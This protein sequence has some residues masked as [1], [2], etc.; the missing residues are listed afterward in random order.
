MVHVSGIGIVVVVVIIVAA[1]N[2]VASPSAPSPLFRRLTDVS[3]WGTPGT[4]AAKACF[5]DD[6]TLLL[7][8]SNSACAVFI[9]YSHVACLSQAL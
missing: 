9:V 5:A 8:I 7:D 4:V 1:C 6:P 3:L 2:G